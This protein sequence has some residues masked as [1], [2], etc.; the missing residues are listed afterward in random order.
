MNGDCIIT[1]VVGYLLK[2]IRKICV[3]MDEWILDVDI[4]NV[5]FNGEVEK[6][7]IICVVDNYLYI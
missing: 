5:I 2:C 3:R 6:V 4:M 7:R 1:I